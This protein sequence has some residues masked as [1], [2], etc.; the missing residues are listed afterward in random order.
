MF[1]IKIIY[2]FLARLWK[3]FHL[4]TRFINKTMN[5]Y[6]FTSESVCAGHPDKICDQISDAIVDAVLKQDKYGRVAVETLVTY[7]R[8]VLAGGGFTKTKN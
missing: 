2:N 4:D 5:T 6:T 7:N 3:P 1:F 8:V